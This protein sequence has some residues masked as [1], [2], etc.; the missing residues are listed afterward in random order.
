[1]DPNNPSFSYKIMTPATAFHR[2]T[3]SDGRGLIIPFDDQDLINL[4]DNHDE[5]N[6]AFLDQYLSKIVGQIAAN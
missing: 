2:D 5:F 4:L 6:S 1:M 3:Y